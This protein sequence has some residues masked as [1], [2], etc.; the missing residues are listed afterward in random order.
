MG[1]CGEALEDAGLSEDHGAR[2]DGHE[3]TFFGGVGFLEGGEGADEGDGEGGWG[4]G[5]VEV[6]GR[7]AAG[8][9]EDVVVAEGGEGVVE[10]GVCFDGEAGGGGYAWG[11]G[12]DGAFEGFG[13]C[14]G[15]LADG[16]W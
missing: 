2:A 16:D 3:G 5:G 10:V 9:D 11:G 15:G 12:G 7:G 6:R 8:D 13:A 4:E 1:G 14:V